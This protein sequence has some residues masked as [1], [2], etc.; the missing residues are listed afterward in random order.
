MASLIRPEHF[1]ALI[2]NEDDNL[3]SH[4]VKFARVSILWW[5]YHRYKYKADGTFTEAYIEDLCK[6][7]CPTTT[8]TTT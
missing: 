3:C 2:P 7:T 8:T 5:Q 6:I 1:K 4:I